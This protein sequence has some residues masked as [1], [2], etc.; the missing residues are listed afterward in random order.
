MKLKVTPPTDPW[1]YAV[2]EQRDY[3]TPEDIDDASK[4]GGKKEDIWKIVLTA[5]G[6]KSCEDWSCCAFVASRLRNKK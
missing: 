1:Y 3:I 4:A 2:N 5:L 6:A